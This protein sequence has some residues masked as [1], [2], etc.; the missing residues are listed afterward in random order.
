M[1][2]RTGAAFDKRRRSGRFTSEYQWRC[3]AGQK[4][5]RERRG[6]KRSFP[7]SQAVLMKAPGSV[8]DTIRRGIV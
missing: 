6:G 2:R 3:F 7:D 5:R 8:E 1:K 4:Y